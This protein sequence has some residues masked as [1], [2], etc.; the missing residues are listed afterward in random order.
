[1][2]QLPSFL[3]AMHSS[4]GSA[5]GGGYGTRRTAT[6]A[7][8][9]NRTGQI[10]QH[11]SLPL[12]NMYNK[13]GKKTKLGSGST[14]DHKYGS[15]VQ[16]M[17]NS[18]MAKHQAVQSANIAD[19]QATQAQATQALGGLRSE[20]SSLAQSTY[21]QAAANAERGLKQQQAQIQANL[22]AQ[23]SAAA[24]YGA[25]YG[26]LLDSMRGRAEQ[27]LDRLQPQ[28]AQAASQGRQA[29]E[30]AAL[31]GYGRLANV[32]L[33]REQFMRGDIAQ[34]EQARAN[35]VDE[36][37]QAL[38]Q[39]EQDRGAALNAALEK[40][41]ESANAYGASEKENIQRA[42]LDH[43][44]NIALQH[45]A[46]GFSTS[47][48]AGKQQG[49]MDSLNNT[50]DVEFKKR[51]LMDAATNDWTT[52]TLQTADSMLAGKKSISEILD[53]VISEAG[54]AREGVGT[55]TT[56]TITQAVTGF[57]EAV[58]AATNTESKQVMDFVKD[59]VL[60]INE[61]E[62]KLDER[63][64]SALQLL[65]NLDMKLI[66]TA[67]KGQIDALTKSVDRIG[68]AIKTKGQMNLEATKAYY[69]SYVEI[70]KSMADQRRQA[71]DIGTKGVMDAYG[72]KFKGL[73]S[74][75]DQRYGREKAVLNAAGS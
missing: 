51:Q 25:A 4:S 3:K 37:R 18:M 62:D 53:R 30:N 67:G 11:G 47:M 57:N 32:A 40:R 66:E 35:T 28:V 68:E 14:T 59:K 10:L 26:N 38:G 39:F 58:L 43:N 21:D 31:A 2:A 70:L 23:R 33:E 71:R 19:I 69:Q 20:S 16:K 49:L 34:T 48:N 46:N 13:R 36:Y 22:D 8:V 6:G 1:M 75:M 52:G 29:A 5:Y 24:G 60:K 73:S 44:A 56:A 63:K 50:S 12:N 45:A 27:T 72:E 55:T 15:T 74:I 61:A 65:G 17:A 64:I 9:D 7:I 54:K 41:I 42:L